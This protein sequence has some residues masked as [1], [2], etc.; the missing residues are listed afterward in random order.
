[1]ILIAD[2]DDSV[3]LSLSLLLKRAG[4]DVKA[5]STPGE[6]L[7]EIRRTRLS[8]IMLDMNFTLSVSG[9]EGIELLRKC[10]VFQPDTPVILITAWGSIPLAVEGMQSGAFDFITKPWDNTDLLRRVAT[11]TKLSPDDANDQTDDF[12]RSEII[13]NSPALESVLQK[14][15]RVAPTDASV[16][17][18]GE[19]GTGKELIARALHINS[20]RRAGEF[21]AVNLGGV[22]RSLFESEMFGHT[23]GAFTGAVAARKGRFETAE[24][25]TIFLDEI[26]DLDQPSQVKLLRVLQERTFEPL[27]ESRPR[28]ADVRVVC[29]TNAHL[30]AMV[31][32]GTFREDLYYRINLITLRLPPLR[33]RREDIPLLVNHF[34]DAY[35]TRERTQRPTISADAMTW[36]ASQ[37]YPGNIRELRNLVERAIIV[38]G[39]ER[40]TANDFKVVAPD[41][42][43]LPGA[44]RALATDSGLTLDELERRAII[45]AIDSS[46]GNL[47]MAASA[48][49]ITR[50]SLYRRM[51]K[52]GLSNP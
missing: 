6:V 22:P 50:Q 34:A 24:G 42:I 29:A 39:C 45:G 3:R 17:I 7:A 30:E 15:R 9:E 13:G 11:A 10:K 5:V 36:L 41:S 40:L 12:D 48:L 31:A 18:L 14:V 27:G 37:P 52:F 19:N 2:D 46:G 43:P 21:V 20:R 1:M 25:G 35:A 8:L 32:D 49:G 44:A 28:K 47:S 26:A 33:E 38:G 4:Y 23:K 16:L 51:Q